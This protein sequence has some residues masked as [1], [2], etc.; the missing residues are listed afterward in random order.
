MVLNVAIIGSSGTIGSAFTNQLTKWKIKFNVANGWQGL[1]WNPTNSTDGIAPWVQSQSSY[2]NAYVGIEFIG[3]GTDDDSFTTNNPA[4]F[5]TEPKEA[6]ELDIYYEVPGSYT[7]SEAGNVHQL[8]F[9][10]AIHLVMVL[11]QI[12]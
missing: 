8:D 2:N 5:E 12:V 7:K 6:A 3:L 10:I 4:I 9:L 1:Q 11:N